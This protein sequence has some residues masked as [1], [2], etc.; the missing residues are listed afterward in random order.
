MCLLSH[1]GLPVDDAMEQQ[2]TEAGPS[3][4]RSPWSSRCLTIHPAANGGTCVVIRPGDMAATSTP[5]TPAATPSAGAGPGTSG[6]RDRPAG[7]SLGDQAGVEERP[8]LDQLA[9]WARE[10]FANPLFRD[11]TGRHSYEGV[12]DLRSVVAGEMSAARREEREWEEVDRLARDLALQLKAKITEIWR[13]K[14]PE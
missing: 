6:T 12:R 5:S 11:P 2:R 8:G 7:S 10:G 3:S 1:L 14:N 13:R 9:Y 4:R